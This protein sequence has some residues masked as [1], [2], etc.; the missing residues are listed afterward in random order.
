MSEGSIDS[1]KGLGIMLAFTAIA[2][3]GA[4]VMYGAPAQ[5]DR[6]W[7]FA[8]ALVFATLAVVAVQIFE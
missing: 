3:V 2:L 1:D 8:A 6:A 5:L 7:G 4:V